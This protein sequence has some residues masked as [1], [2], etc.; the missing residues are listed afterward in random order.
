MQSPQDEV[1]EGRCLDPEDHAED[2]RWRTIAVQ[3]RGNGGLEP[4]YRRRGQN[5][6][7]LKIGGGALPIARGPGRSLWRRT[8]AATVLIGA[9]LAGRGE[10]YR[11]SNRSPPGEPGTARM[12]ILH[13]MV[14]S[15]GHGG[16]SRM[17]VHGMHREHG[18]RKK[19]SPCRDYE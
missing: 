8:E 11:S 5:L 4:R 1:L 18:Q 6:D 3:E 17:A 10:F 19:S 9:G 15:R 14:V 13:S 2:G 12:R 16:M 7:H